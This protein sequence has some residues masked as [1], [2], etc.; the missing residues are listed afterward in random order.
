M[1]TLTKKSL[2]ALLSI[3]PALVQA[4]TTI[5]SDNFSSSSLNPGSYPAVTPNSTG[6]EIASSKNATSTSMSSGHLALGTSATTSGITEAQA[7]FSATPVTLASAGDFIRLTYTFTDTANIMNGV[8]TDNT[9]FFIGL[10][11]SAGSA[12]LSGLNNGGIAAAQ[13]GAATGGVK[14]WVGYVGNPSYAST[15]TVRPTSV[16]T[17]PAQAQANNTVQELVFPNASGGFQNKVNI[18]QA[19]GPAPGP[20]LTV[21]NQY[22]V[23][24]KLTYDGTGLLVETALFEGA[25]TSG[26][27]LLAAGG[28]ATG[29]N[30]LTLSYDGMALGYRAGASGVATTFDINSVSVTA[31]I[32]VVPEPSSAALV[33]SGITLLGLIQRSRRA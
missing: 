28:T 30:L 22:T 14:D 12:P 1:K 4:D 18:G 27:T 3:A 24:L 25:G 7:L 21:G 11:N 32:A 19:N 26:T 6:Y 29:A 20:S 17:R 13:T 16:Y 2:L 31:N 9:G 5:F 23:D 8:A 10:Y 33:L 15:A